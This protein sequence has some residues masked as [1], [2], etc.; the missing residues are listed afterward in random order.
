MGGLMAEIDAWPV[1]FAVKFAMFS[2]VGGD[3]VAGFK[4]FDETAD[5]NPL[6]KAWVGSNGK[7]N[8][9]GLACAASGGY[10]KRKFEDISRDYADIFKIPVA[11]G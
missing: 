9:N 8:M 1:S 3:G 6:P 7:S 2:L 4:P 11:K 10:P 5:E